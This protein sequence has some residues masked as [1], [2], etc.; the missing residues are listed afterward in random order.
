MAVRFGWDYTAFPLWCDLSVSIP[1][2]FR[3]ALQAWSD[4]G[5]EHFWATLE[6]GELPEGWLHP[7]VEMGRSL[8]RAATQ[9]V[10][11]IEYDNQETHETELLEAEPQE[12]GY[13][14]PEEAALG[15]FTRGAEAHVVSVEWINDR[16]ARVVVD[17]VPSHPITSD[18]HQDLRGRW[19]EWS[20]G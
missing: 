1:D 17:T 6:G 3:D 14:S 13:A 4:E 19:S 18:V 5:T 15:G 16:N 12:D 11:D 10:G 20:A 7:W 9:L 2:D 8:A